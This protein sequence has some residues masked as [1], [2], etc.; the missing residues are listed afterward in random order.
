M[1]QT[2]ID[3]IL[4]FL[5][6]HKGMEFNVDGVL[7]GLGWKK[8]KKA[9]I[10]QSLNRLH[11]RGVLKKPHRGFYAYPKDKKSKVNLKEVLD[12]EKVEMHNIR[13]VSPNVTEIDP[14][15]LLDTKLQGDTA[16]D[17]LRSLFKQTKIEIWEMIGNK[18]THNTI[19]E[20]RALRIERS[21]IIEISLMAGEKP[22]DEW[23]MYGFH[24]F[25]KGYFRP[26]DFDAIPWKIPYAEVNID[27]HR[28][29]ITPTMITMQDYEGV[30][31]RWY[32]KKSKGVARREN[33]TKLEGTTLTELIENLRGEQPIGVVSLNKKL[34]LL[35]E[36]I[37]E[38]SKLYKQSQAKDQKLMDMLIELKRDKPLVVR[39]NE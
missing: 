15:P 38:L 31:Q 35:M 13:L 8:T 18:E 3:L 12:E 37:R 11:E 20:G 24:Q 19:W 4:E 39:Y 17:K 1:P 10:R 29:T 32:Q 9:T 34:D 22:L 28:V 7:T 16:R 25:L 27:T 2:D 23:E 33:R 14:Y 6:L 36:G 30:Y 5:E 26:I 21:S